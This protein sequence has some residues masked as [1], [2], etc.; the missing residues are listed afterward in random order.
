LFGLLDAALNRGDRDCVRH[1]RAD[2]LLLHH[3]KADMWVGDVLDEVIDRIAA[4][5]RDSFAA[6]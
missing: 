1:V 4:E 6:S 3:H 5:K 2:G